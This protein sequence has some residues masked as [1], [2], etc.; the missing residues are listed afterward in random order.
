MHRVVESEL[1]NRKEV[2]PML[3]TM[4]IGAE[5]FLQNAINAFG[6]TIRLRV[7]SRGHAKACP[8]LTKHIRP[9]VRSESR[10][11][12]R[13]DLDRHPME[14]KHCLHEETSTAFG[15]NRLGDRSKMNHL[16]EAV[17]EYDDS[18]VSIRVFRQ[19]EH[20]VHGDGLPAL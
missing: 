15:C 19:A 17:H 16:T 11:S 2:A 10:I 1:N 14:S 8:Q 3:K 20:E 12:I 5:D 6:L 4:S 18:V 9:K 13:D 7:V